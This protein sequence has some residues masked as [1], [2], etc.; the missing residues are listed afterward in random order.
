M[1]F[2]SWKGTPVIASHKEYCT[3][4]CALRCVGKTGPNSLTKTQSRQEGQDQARAR[5]SAR[6]RPATVSRGRGHRPD[7]R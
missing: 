2:A 5:R 6:Q 7:D 4:Q 3:A 1:K